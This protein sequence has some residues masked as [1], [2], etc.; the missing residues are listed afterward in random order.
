MSCRSRLLCAVAVIFL[1][2]GQPVGADE[3]PAWPPKLYG[4]CMELPAVPNPSIPA[5]A[6]LLR[7]LGFDGVGYPLWFGDELDKNLGTLDEAGVE[8]CL[9]YMTVNV[10]PQ[11]PAFDARVPEAIAKLKG[12]RV[13]ISVLLRGFPSGDPRGMQ[14][15][16]TILRELGDLAAKSDLRISIYH[17]LNDWTESLLYSLEVVKNVDR[18]NVGVNFNLCHWLK[19]DGDKDYRPVLRENVD[20]IFAVTINGA[21]RDSTAWTGGLI[22]PL[23][24]GDFDNRELLG[25]LRE[26]G[27]DGP[28]GLMCYGIPDDTREHL[29]RSMQVWKAWQGQFP[30]DTGRLKGVLRPQGR[31]M[32]LASVV[33]VASGTTLSRSVGIFS[34]YRLLETANRHGH[35]A[36]DWPSESHRLADGAIEAAW[37]ADET[38]PF[39]MK[40]VYRWPKP[41]T[42]DLVTTVT[43]KK[44]LA[45]FEV[46]LA[47]YFNGFAESWVYAKGPA[48]TGDKAGFLEAGRDH[49]TWQMFPRD[50]RAIETIRDGRWK[51]PPNPVQ[52][53]IRPALIGPLGMRRDLQTGLVALVMAPPEDCFAVATPHGEDGHRSLYLSLFGQ[54]IKA[55]QTAVARSRLVI[56]RGV[57]FEDAVRIYEEYLDECN[58]A[59]D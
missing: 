5:Q 15:A 54:D 26:I 4:L 10:D 40:A 53:T 56:R 21:Q 52:W 12:R 48:Q 25:L 47:S 22:Q 41:D 30:F 8:L 17:H 58:D 44:D 27:Y 55:G 20:R 39:D 49:G 2:S 34:H 14:R 19:V 43:A 1:L 51:Q 42:L 45:R 35:A 29:Q 36:W 59:N 28:V 11:R 6:K 3:N 16:V 46:F 32:G 31:S 57:S 33:D 50:D 18:P 24:R 13:T 23:D 37:T 7:E 9:V 38:H